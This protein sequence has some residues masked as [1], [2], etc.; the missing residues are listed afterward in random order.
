[1]KTLHFETENKISLLIIPDAAAHAN[2]HPVI[3]YTYS[4]YR[5]SGL[6]SISMDSRESDLHLE[7]HDDPDYL[8]YIVFE[9]PDKLFTYLPYGV[10]PL[11]KGEAE[12]V[13]EYISHIR[14]NPGLW[15]L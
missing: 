11:D 8:G 14:D 13:I 9:L 7:K 2:G 1:M 15:Q 4:I 6:N 10:H 12:E 3:S 5:D